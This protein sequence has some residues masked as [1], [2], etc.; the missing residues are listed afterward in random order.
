MILFFKLMILIGSEILSENQLQLYAKI[1]HH[2]FI[3]TIYE[4]FESVLFLILGKQ[5]LGNL[6]ACLI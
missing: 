3:L 1:L 5:K 4:N 6:H 2:N